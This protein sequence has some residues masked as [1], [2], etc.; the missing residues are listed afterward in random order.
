MHK[1]ENNRELAHQLGQQ[2]RELE[3]SLA[4]IWDIS[5]SFA[6][7]VIRMKLPDWTTS[8]AMLDCIQCDRVSFVPAWEPAAISIELTNDDANSPLRISDSDNLSIVCESVRLSIVH[9]DHRDDWF[10]G[11]SGVT[12]GIDLLDRIGDAKHHP[13]HGSFAALMTYLDGYSHALNDHQLTWMPHKPSFFAFQE[14]VLKKLGMQ[15]TSAGWRGAITHKYPDDKVAYRKFFC[16]LAR[17]R[18]EYAKGRIPDPP[19][20]RK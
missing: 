9:D 1:A 13:A 6:A 19:P 18:K 14:W 11:P 12:N 16:L 17:F 10:R 7:V 3:G 20:A 8:R 15:N 5:R 4:M 2:L